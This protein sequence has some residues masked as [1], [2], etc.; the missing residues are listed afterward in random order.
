MEWKKDHFR[1][2][3]EKN[4]LF[5]SLKSIVMERKGPV[6]T[7]LG[8]MFRIQWE[9]VAGR[10]LY[11]LKE[12]AT[13]EDQD[14]IREQG[15]SVFLAVMPGREAALL[16][17]VLQ[18]DELEQ[19]QEAIFHGWRELAREERWWLY[20]KCSMPGEEQGRGWRRGLYYA[21]GD[22]EEAGRPREETHVVSHP[23][24]DEPVQMGLFE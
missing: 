6:E 7:E 3:T 4:K 10:A 1:L 13:R 8:R 15:D 14:E 22:N 18:E 2:D 24:R 20:R 21:L 19:C 12:Q 11:I 9:R 23:K 5:V 16:F 17:W